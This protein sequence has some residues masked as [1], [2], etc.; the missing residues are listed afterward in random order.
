MLKKIMIFTV[1]L[2]FG[3]NIFAQTM[4]DAGTS[5]N[6]GNEKYTAKDYAGAI[7]S[8]KESLDFCNAVGFEADDL[9]V[10]AQKQLNN[11]YYKNAIALY[12]KRKF[13]DAIS[14]FT[15]GLNL[16]EEIG[17]AS[18]K[19][20][21]INYIAKVHSTKGLTLIKNG[22]LD[23]ALVEYDAAHA[24]KPNCV[25]AFYGKA[26]VY[27]EK[28]DMTL[29][30]ENADKAI[31]NGAGNSKADKYVGKTKSL[32]SKA[33]LNEGTTELSKEH[34]AVAAKYLTASMKY[35]DGT[36]D[37]YYYLAIAY[38]KSKAYTKAIEAANKA[39]ELQEGDK[40]DIYFEIGQAQEG[41]GNAAGACAAYKKV[42]G[43]NN[44]ETAKYQITT[45]L[46]CS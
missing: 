36:A 14:N 40:S 34:G 2:F 4:D 12:K 28:G 39:L 27:K 43:G 29:M 16:S 42:T 21:N 6:D 20:K 25:N 5:Y 8:F 7:V 22:K 26:L 17:D 15:N 33:L 24:I 3:A 9:K 19:T 45:V 37:T 32:A 46:K 23:E 38:N 35:A 30:M 10:R 11:S 31:E 13:D 41:N 44:I 1:V 18:K